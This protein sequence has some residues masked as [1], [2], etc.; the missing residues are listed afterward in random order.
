MPKK[1]QVACIQLNSGSNIQANLDQINVY[2]QQASEQNCQLVLLPENFSYICENQNKS[3]ENAQLYQL[4]ID[5][6]AQKA[7]QFK[8]W[9]IA[10]SMLYPSKTKQKFY[11]RCLCFKP[12]GSIDKS[13]DKMHL[14][15]VAL[16]TEKWQESK[17]IEAGK[18]PCMIDYDAHWKLG[19]SI[20]YDLRFPELFRYYSA[21]G[22]QIL[23]VAAA[24][25]VPT[26]MAHW[27]TL[28]RARAIENQ[29][30]VLA[31]AQ[32]GQHADGRQTYGHSLI[33]DPWGK[34]LCQLERGQ[35]MIT[36]QLDLDFIEKVRQELPALQH[37]KDIV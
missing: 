15:D 3:I 27:H 12:D 23:C 16:A 4:T 8:L 13:Y 37:V 29:C 32:T 36:A 5:F 24:F 9:I 1:L 25:T 22:C 2:L 18:Q 11:N 34:I 14:F 7:R 21:Q 26:G 6:L 10:G 35:G 20:C 33:I 28:L 30:Y 31:S 17:H 19:L